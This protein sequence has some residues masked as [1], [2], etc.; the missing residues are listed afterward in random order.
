M[1]WLSWPIMT[2]PALEVIVSTSLPPSGFLLLGPA[3]QAACSCWVAMTVWASSASRLELEL[4]WCCCLHVSGSQSQQN[5][6]CHACQSACL[7][8]CCCCPQ[9][10][11]LLQQCIPVAVLDSKGAAAACSW[12]TICSNCTCSKCCQVAQRSAAAACSW[13]ITS[14]NACLLLIP[15]QRFTLLPAAVG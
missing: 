8:G 12:S 11:N 10:G 14:S 2:L 6:V 3:V 13:L 7:N 1:S 4:E 9:L 5:P 15:L